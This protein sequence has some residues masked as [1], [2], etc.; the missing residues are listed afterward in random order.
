MPCAAKDETLSA[1]HSS[2]GFPCTIS[3]H[4]HSHS[5]VKTDLQMRA[6]GPGRFI[7]CWGQSWYAADPGISWAAHLQSHT[8][9]LKH[10][11]E[12]N[13]RATERA[14]PWLC[15]PLLPLAGDLRHIISSLILSASC[16]QDGGVLS[17][18]QSV[19]RIQ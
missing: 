11:Q 12:S 15:I 16:L 4:P 8:P 3:F 9:R 13:C 7:T 19:G 1:R 18:L 14:G 17:S 2:K 5:I 6:Q 10:R